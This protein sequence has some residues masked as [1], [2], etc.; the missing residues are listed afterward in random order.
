MKNISKNTKNKMISGQHYVVLLYPFI[1]S[2][3]MIIIIPFS[4]KFT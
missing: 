4:N 1:Y 2:K 3:L